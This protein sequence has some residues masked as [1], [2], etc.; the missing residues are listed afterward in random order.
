MSW[1]RTVHY[2]GEMMTVSGRIAKSVDQWYGI[3]RVPGSIS[4][5][6]AHFSHPVTLSLCA[7][8]GT[9]TQ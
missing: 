1:F 3:P 2:L 4:G 8:L 7:Q 9:M 5:Q 6:A